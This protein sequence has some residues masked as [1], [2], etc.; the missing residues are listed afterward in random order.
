[1]GRWPIPDP[2]D[3]AYLLQAYREG[4]WGRYPGGF[5]ET[6]EKEFA[7][8]HDAKYAVA[9]TSGTTALMLSYLAL[10]LP[11]QTKFVTPAYTFIA[12]ATA[13]IVLGLIP[14]FVDIDFETLTIDVNHLAEV[15]E[16]DKENS[17]KLIVPVHFAGN[18]ADM[19]KVL[20]LARK[21]GAYVVEDAAQ[22]HGVSYKGRKVGAIGDTGIFSFQSGKMM[23]A[24]EGGM[25]LTNSFELYEK[26][27]SYHH[28]GRAIGGE[29]YE[30]IRVGLNFRMTELQAAVILAQLR[31]FDKMLAKIKRNAKIIYDELENNPHIHLHKPP[32]Y[33]ETNYY[34]IPISLNDELL[35]K[36][37][38]KKLAQIMNEKGF[39]IIEGY[40]KPLYKQKAFEEKRWK[41]PYEEYQKLYLKATEEACNRTMWIPHYELIYDDDYTIRYAKTLSNSIKEML[42]K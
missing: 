23:T 15:L 26:I 29:W 16:K 25:V 37:G 40:M 27:W 33:G 21:H 9:V 7:K 13:G 17:I 10:D 41:L 28:A 12:T 8:Y 24:G 34:F 14:V 38:K 5:V 11:P 35:A 20:S 18:P 6:L 39:R 42:G 2:I 3:E 32:S 36:G 4:V 30:H 31:R 22:A 19:D 1:L